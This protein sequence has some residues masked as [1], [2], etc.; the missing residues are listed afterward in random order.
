MNKNSTPPQPPA[1]VVNL[2]APATPKI[3]S[4]AAI[5]PPPIEL[6]HFADSCDR[7]LDN[8]NNLDKADY[9]LTSTAIREYI[10]ALKE[11]REKLDPEYLYEN[12][13]RKFDLRT[14]V[15]GARLSLMLG[16]FTTSAAP[17]EPEVFTASLL[18]HVIAEAESLTALALCTACAEIETSRASLP[19]I[20]V[21]LETLREH[22]EKW[23]DR[24]LALHHFEV[25]AKRIAD[26]RADA[27][28]A[29]HEEACARAG[30]QYARTYDAILQKQEAARMLHAEIIGLW[31]RLTYDDARI[32][33]AQ[34][35]LAAL[36]K[37]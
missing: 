3:K 2:P 16:S 24:M 13:R 10:A 26:A 29:D 25:K 28:R 15:I 14:E 6:K 18:D 17:A 33:N 32:D 31:E 4:R 5:F 19:S 34:F 12:D 35:D 9:L 11:Q 7:L 1:T 37:R 23:A 36:V 8:Y 27:V 20:K 21:V 30:E 22:A